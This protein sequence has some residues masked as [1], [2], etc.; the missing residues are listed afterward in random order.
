MDNRNHSRGGIRYLQLAQNAKS[1]PTWNMILQQ[2]TDAAQEEVR[3]HELNRYCGRVSGRSPTNRAFAAVV[4]WNQ[5]G[6]VDLNQQHLREA[7]KDFD[8]ALAVNSKLA[9]P[10]PIEEASSL[11]DLAT[12][13]GERRQP[14]KA[15]E[16]LHQAYGCLE[17]AHQTESRTA[18]LVRANLALTLEQ[19]GRFAEAEAAY[20]TAGEMLSH[21][22]GENNLEYARILSNRALLEWRVGR[23]RD[24]ADDG[25]LAIAIQ[26]KLPFVGR[27]DRSLTLNNLGLSLG[28]LG[29]FEAAESAMLQAARIEKAAPGLSDQLVSSL[30]NL[31]N[32]ERSRGRL[33]EATQYEDELDK[34]LS[35]GMKVDALT[36]CSVW[37]TF[38]RAAEM[39]HDYRKADEFYNK[40]LRLLEEERRLNDTHYAATLSNMASLDSR[41]RRYKKAESLYRQA[42]E[43]DTAALGTAHPVVASDLSNIATQLFYLKKAEASLPLYQEAKKIQE[44]S[45]GPFSFE[46]ARTWRNLAIT[47]LSLNQVSESVIAFSQ[48]LRAIDV[49][50]GGQNPN[51]PSWLREYAEALRR[52]QHF[53]EAEAAETRA[54]GIE[55]RNT[56]VRQ[57]GLA[58]EQGSKKDGSV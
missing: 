36:Q 8:Q 27:F 5:L 33:K 18:A 55:V 41:R 52:E 43:I 23:Y 4:L 29:D 47:H 13:V 31:A 54:L 58:Q 56:V 15:E 46:V 2:A 11:N 37:N 6:D 32:L 20:K 51:L 16:L 14:A 34:T 49:S 40:A 25:K 57:K 1:P 7:E 45:L 38:A 17:K 10:S 19:E 28:A 44:Q 30:N 21:V 26:D 3:S 39:E 48:A 9:I 24:A 22:S 35:A 53:G 42:L 50:S 12:I